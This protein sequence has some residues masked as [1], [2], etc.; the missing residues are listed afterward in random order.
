MHDVAEDQQALKA[1]KGLTLCAEYRKGSLAVAE[2]DVMV[3][4]LKRTLIIS[5]GFFALFWFSASFLPGNAAAIGDFD[6]ASLLY[7][8]HGV[9]VIAAW[10]YG[11]KSIVYLA[12]G[13]YLAHFSRIPEHPDLWSLGE[14]LQPM[15]GVVCVAMTFEV[16]ARLGVDLRLRAGFRAPW[17]SILLV[18]ALASLI[19]AIG[20]NLVVQNPPEVMLGYLVGDI[21]GMILLFLVVMLI[22]RGLRRV[23]Y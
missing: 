8:P 18:G 10:L 16:V 2:L 4:D 14:A 19:N 6:Y 20:A 15:F 5:G 13:A 3:L 22:F 11:W 21:L 9:R 17:R 7:L 12:P 23:G 1:S